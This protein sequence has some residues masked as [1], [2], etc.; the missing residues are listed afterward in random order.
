MIAEQAH[1]HLS[2]T[3]GPSHVFLKVEVLVPWFSELSLQC[4]PEHHG[5]QSDGGAYRVP[6]VGRGGL[7][8]PRRTAL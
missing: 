6:A 7:N 8:S 3:S 5:S 2:H 1:Y 4:N